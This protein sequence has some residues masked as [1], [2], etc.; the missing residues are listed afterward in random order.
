MRS[1]ITLIIIFSS[2]AA[3]A[4]YEFTE[5]CQRAMQE[6]YSL[7]PETA[8]A[9]LAEEERIHPDNSYRIFL[10]HY[11]DAIEI[12][13]LEDESK[14]EIFREKYYERRDILDEEDESSPFH[15][16]IEAEM[17]MHLGL[18]YIKFG[19]MLKGAGKVFSSYKLIKANQEDFPDFIYDDKLAGAYNMIFA[20][21]PP[22]VR[23]AARMIGIRG[24]MEKGFEQIKQ[25][26]EKVV[27][28]P[29][30]AE[31]SVLVMNF[32]YKIMWR[33]AEGYQFL[34]SLDSRFYN[35][36]LISYF[37]ANHAAWAAENDLALELLS[38][39]DRD[40]LEVEFY[41]MDYLTG[42]C[43]LNRLDD[44]ADVW[45]RRYLNGF[46]GDDYKKDV[47]NRLS[48][49][50][51]IQGDKGA[52]KHYKNLVEEIG[53]DLRDRDREA[54]IEASLEYDPNIHLLKARLLFDG[55]YYNLS[56]NQLDEFDPE[57]IDF[58]PYILE[59]HYR[60]GRVYQ[61]TARYEEAVTEL[62]KTIEMGED[63]DL[64][65]AT[66]AALAL[67]ELYE[68]TGDRENAMKSYEL[69]LDLYDS[70]HS[71]EGIENKAEKRL[72]RLEEVE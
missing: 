45:L 27:D 2:L 34:S 10:E 40:E 22:V 60:R 28:I 56:D 3:S 12:V 15:Q 4:Y 61:K 32:G 65:F 49:Y 9:I 38:Q 17:L 37:Y 52:Y 14:Y 71:A 6:I 67:G 53:D 18:S 20:N 55:G 44:D 62:N 66:R 50:Y 70:D 63:E 58:K 51:F 13:I 54:I 64:T 19:S 7:R 8:R 43:K 16:M 47:S 39:I 46:P 1:L 72:E 5:N 48:W 35:C 26:H 29:G 24:D 25:Y 59:Y 41:G 11:C 30:M 21:I 42:R 33:E 31:E 57:T 69:C 68:E 23:W 36:T